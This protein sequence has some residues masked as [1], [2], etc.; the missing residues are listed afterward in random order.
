MLSFNIAQ[1]SR[2]EKVRRVN[3]K[4]IHLGRDILLGL[5]LAVFGL[6]LVYG[7]NLHTLY[8]VVVH[9]NHVSA[10]NVV[11]LTYN[12]KFSEEFPES[13]KNE[14]KKNLDT[15][16]N[17]KLNVKR[18]S[19]DDT[20]ETDILISTKEIE[21]NSDKSIQLS[22]GKLIPVGH[23][24]SLLREISSSKLSNYNI[25][26]LNDLYKQYIEYTYNVSVNIT[27]NKEE[28]ISKL[29]ESD[30]NIAFVEF[31]D[32][33]PS[34]KVL[35]LDSKNYLD[36]TEHGYLQT[37]MYSTVVSGKGAFILAI[38]QNLLN[39]ESSNPV[40]TSKLSKVNMSGVVA[41]S[42]ALA[43][44]MNALKSTTYPADAI[45]DF[46]ADADLTHVSNEAS[47]ADDCVISSG[48]RFCSKWE[49]MDV[50]KK[51]GVDIVELT[52]NHNN[53]TG[54]K[55]NTAT[56][57]KYKELGIHYFGGGLNA[58][59]ASK[60][61]YEEVKG[62]KIAFIGYNFYDTYYDN[63]YVLAG[64]TTAGANSYSKEK[65]TKDISTAK[66]NADIVIVDFQFQ[67]CYCYPDGDVVYPPCYKPL[68]NPDQVEVFRSAIDLGATIVIGTQ[69][70]QPQ[71]YEVYNNGVIFYGLGN[72]YFDQSN[73]IG[74]RQGLVL[75]HYFY[76]GKYL[77]TKITPTYMDY[78]LQPDFATEQQYNQLMNSLKE[79]RNSL[80]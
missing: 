58:E 14:I 75:S 62:T 3:E 10:N 57:N 79:A 52:G 55:N 78:D 50:L 29:K 19:F 1:N 6:I 70:H 59:D 33:E 5:L 28:L 42:R 11:Y 37:T 22:S 68:G 64:E 54:N 12:V 77:S 66:E 26:V 27:T 15:V 4:K 34:L 49:Y 40:D 20:K 41:L 65:M 61:L 25:Y 24:Y 53:D 32:L 36:D 80:L 46:L 71:T 16:V 76:D 44:K 67:E 38:I 43:S 2:V 48:M 73:W 23:M 9:P 74:T 56:I 17:E 47:F 63:T 31:T 39:I 51:S 69:A 45:G 60:I 21:N 30:D 72:L 35:S 7:K 8:N 18:F 13:I